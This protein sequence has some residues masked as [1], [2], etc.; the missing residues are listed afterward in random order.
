MVICSEKRPCQGNEISDGSYVSVV[1]MV[2]Y[3]SPGLM[4]QGLINITRPGH[5]SGVVYQRSS[6]TSS[7]SM[8]ERLVA[9]THD[10]WWGSCS[11]WQTG[12]LA[13]GLN[14]P[15]RPCIRSVMVMQSFRAKWPSLSLIRR[16]WLWGGAF[17]RMTG[18][19]DLMVVTEL[20][21]SS[22]QS[23]PQTLAMTFMLG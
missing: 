22:V 3:C 15:G 12:R 14:R 23:T 10:T 2:A 16:S 5:L 21:P 1:E 11:A 13:D 4:D 6:D 17:T 7:C 8:N 18:S 19:Q 20:T 9:K